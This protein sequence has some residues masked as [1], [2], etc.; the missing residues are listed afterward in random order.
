MKIVSLAELPDEGV[1]HDPDISK[2]VLLRRGDVPHVTN[3][4]HARLA[5]GQATRSHAHT[6]MHEV[7]LVLAGTGRAEVDG[8]AHALAAGT[9]VVVEPGESHVMRNTGA[10]ELVLAY[11]GVEGG[12]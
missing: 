10:D 5:P 4:S 9:C 7:Y 6:T 8:R 1:S 12:A 3:L 11:F 2:R